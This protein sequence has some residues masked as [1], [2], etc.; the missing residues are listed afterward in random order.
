MND[1][2]YHYG[3]KG[4]RWGVRRAQKQLGNLTERHYKQVSEK[5]AQKF[6]SDVATVKNIKSKSDRQA[7]VVTNTTKLGGKKYAEAVLKQANKE[8]ASSFARKALVTAGIAAVAAYPVKLAYRFKSVV[9][10]M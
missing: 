5:E 9:N 3:V 7:Y 2:L 8:S 10:E 6:R 4:M 1:E